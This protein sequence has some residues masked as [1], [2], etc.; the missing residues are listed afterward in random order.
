VRQSDTVNQQGIALLGNNGV[1]MGWISQND[2]GQIRPRLQ[3]GEILL[4]RFNQI[5]PFYWINKGGQCKRGQLTLFS[6]D[7]TGH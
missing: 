1:F 3:R 6:A 5:K 2:I 4:G 7:L